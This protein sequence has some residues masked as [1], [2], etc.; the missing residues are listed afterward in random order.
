MIEI[1]DRFGRE[2]NTLRVS[3]LSSCNLGCVYCTLGEYSDKPKKGQLPVADFMKYITR[4]HEQLGLKSVR[5][6]G[7]EP[8]LYNELPALIEGIK[9]VDIK[10]IKLTTNGFML[11]RMAGRLK[12]AGLQSVNV[13][14]DAV[15]EPAFYR[16]S[17]R[18]G[19][20]RVLAGIAAALA[21]GLEVKINA[22]IMRDL[23]EDQILPLVRYAFSQNIQI[24]FL[25]VMAMGHLHQQA[26]QYLI[27]Q[28]EILTVL[29]SEYAFEH[30][31][32]KASATATYWQTP[33]GNS[34]G[35]IANESEPFCQDCN[36][37]RL[38]A[39]GNIW[40]CLSSNSPISIKDVE[41]ADSL[42]DK[43]KEALRQKQEVRF[44]GSRLSMLKIGG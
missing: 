28:K 16:M 34:F 14:L 23:N 8:L 42:R 7:G 43:L 11:E 32:R 44:I 12:E 10:E 24:R 41:E 36:R 2:F 19:V 3:L 21:A 27:T 9:A 33:A 38:D 30:V 18:R 20:Q 15:D 4:L 26:A 39:Q 35:M 13:S 17:K 29:A 40:G 37:L 25:E 22:V 5:L 1:K 31:G 6:T